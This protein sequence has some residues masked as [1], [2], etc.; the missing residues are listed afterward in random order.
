[1]QGSDTL[2]L[3]ICADATLT[4]GPIG[5]TDKIIPQALPLCTVAD[6]DEAMALI[7]L[8]GSHA[9]GR[10]AKHDRVAEG[11]GPPDRYHYSL[12]D[13]RR[14]DPETIAAAGKTVES[15]RDALRSGDRDAVR[16]AFEAAKGQ[17]GGMLVP[18]AYAEAR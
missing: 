16:R 4:Y 8:I 2:T 18:P 7:T 10:Y 6:E 14:G 1:M 13:F 5:G 15:I 12:E 11:Y 9:T 17:G 3:Y